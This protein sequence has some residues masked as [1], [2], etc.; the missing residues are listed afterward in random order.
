MVGD[1]DGIDGIGE[2]SGVGD[3]GGKCLGGGCVGGGSG[4]DSHVVLVVLYKSEGGEACDSSSSRVAELAWI[5]S[6]RS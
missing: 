4:H 3:G 2:I 6:L 5:S 1:G